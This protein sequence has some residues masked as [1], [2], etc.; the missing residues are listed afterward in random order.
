MEQ[1]SSPGPSKLRRACSGIVGIR[2]LSVVCR[3]WRS[4]GPVAQIRCSR[5]VVNGLGLS[6]N[7]CSGWLVRD[8]DY[9]FRSG[10][11]WKKPCVI[12]ARQRLASSAKISNRRS[13]IWRAETTSVRIISNFHTCPCGKNLKAA[14]CGGLQ[15]VVHQAEHRA[16]HPDEHQGENS[17][18]KD[19]NAG[20]CRHRRRYPQVE[21]P[22]R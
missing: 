5:P 3:R 9:C 11:R 10:G 19:K 17:G 21:A 16:L 6:Q 12:Q 2:R 4:S 14:S 20:G 15:A 7:T 13:R 18:G 1:R 22:Q 8:G